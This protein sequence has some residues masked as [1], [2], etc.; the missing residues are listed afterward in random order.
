MKKSYWI[1]IALLGTAFILILMIGPFL[2]GT[3]NN[4][5]WGMMGGWPGSTLHGWGFGSIG[6]F[7]LLIM[8]LMPVGIVSLAILGII[9]LVRNYPAISGGTPI[10]NKDEDS[11]TSPREILQRRYA[12]GD[13]T[14]DQYLQ[15]LDDVE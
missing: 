7:G 2:L 9:W 10:I 12:R 8:W 1:T 11:P 5:G 14:R 6:W 4:M 13:I 15:M 3:W